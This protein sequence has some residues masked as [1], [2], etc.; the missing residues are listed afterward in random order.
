MRAAGV[1]AAYEA[2]AAPLRKRAEANR[3]R[4]FA[5]GKAKRPPAKPHW[6]HVEKVPAWEH[7]A[8]RDEL[9]AKREKR[10]DW[11][12]FAEN[13]AVLAAGETAA[14][15]HGFRLLECVLT[16]RALCP[17]CAAGTE[18]DTAPAGACN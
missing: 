14:G 15:G 4:R 18:P 9:L 12:S 3:K 16:V 10:E 8:R 13:G 6:I 7:A 2:W 11:M 5:N 1:E 17:S